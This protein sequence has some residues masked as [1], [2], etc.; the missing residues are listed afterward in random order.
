MTALCPG[1]EGTV[2]RPDLSP[3]V[4]KI[5]EN[6]YLLLL[7][8]LIALF[9]L[10]PY[11]HMSPVVQYTL[12]GVGIAMVVLAVRAANLR[13][14]QIVALMGFGL[15]GRVCGIAAHEAGYQLLAVAGHA[16][17]AAFLLCVAVL[18]LLPVMRSPRVTMDM[19]FGTACTY[20]FLGLL[21]AEL[22]MIVEITVPGAFNVG[23]ALI[24]GD[25]P[26]DFGYLTYYSFITLTTVGYGDVSPLHP[27]ARVL[28]MLEGIVGQ[29]YMA[30][31]IARIVG[32]QISSSMSKDLEDY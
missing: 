29:L 26:G 11:A 14:V 22:Y 23:T 13:G 9:A 30:I 10:H 4:L 32:L 6:R 3:A 20:L 15:A 25:E 1:T 27:T 2:A 5:L 28:A 12:A 17:G 21:W 8:T 31:V 7:V 16:V 24:A 19:V 18:I